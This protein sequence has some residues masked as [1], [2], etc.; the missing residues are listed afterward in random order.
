MIDNLEFTKELEKRIKQYIL[1]STRITE[2][3]YDQNYRRDWFMFSEERICLSWLSMETDISFITMTFRG[4]G[5]IC[6]PAPLL[7]R[8]LSIW[9]KAVPT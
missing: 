3:I 9:S 6:S 4:V 8:R 2:E 1:S 7:K 5:A